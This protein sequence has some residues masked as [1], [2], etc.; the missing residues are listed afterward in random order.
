LKGRNHIFGSLL[1][2][3]VLMALVGSNSCA[4]SA[5]SANQNAPTASASATASL[6]A[7]QNISVIEAHNLVNINEDNPDFKILD[8]RTQA[9][10]QS[11]HLANAFNVDIY[12]QDF[13]SQMSQLDR[14]RQYLVYCRTGARSA[15]ASQT[16]SKLGFS[17]IFNMLQGIS[18]WIASGYPTVS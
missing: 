17:H 10:Y 7:L 15:Q 13:E 4:N 5:T 18:D 1:V 6:A 16:M 2:F 12:S 14:N 11:G 8:V 9:E 3:I